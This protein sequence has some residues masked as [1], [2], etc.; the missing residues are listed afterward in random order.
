[1]FSRF[2]ASATRSSRLLIGVVLL[3]AI[4]ITAQPRARA[5]D[6]VKTGSAL[7]IIP[8]D[9]A[10]FGTMLRNKEQFDLFYNSNAYKTLRSLPLVKEAADKLEKEIA[11]DPGNPFAMYQQF[12]KDP[13]NKELVDLLLEGV[14]DEFFVYGGKGWGDMITV[15]ARV[16]NA[17]SWG[18]LQG[19]LG[20]GDPQKA[21]FRAILL[22]LQNSRELL[23]IPDTV[24]GFKLKD[25]KKADNQI[26]RLEKIAGF[27]V[28]QVPQLKGKMTSKKIGDGTFLT[29]E[30]DGSLIPWG[31]VNVKEYEE[32]ND[33]FDPLIKQAQKTTAALSVGIKDGYLL[34]GLTSTS[35]D[36]AKIGG[37]GKSLAG[38]P[39]MAPLAKAAG[40]PLT[41]IGYSS[42]AFIDSASGSQWDFE[43]VAKSL[44]EILGK[45][46]QISAERKKAIE[47]DLDN[48]AADA[49]KYRRE[50]GA[51]LS[52]S[53][54]TPTGFEAF[55]YDYSKHDEL[56]G[57]VC[58]LQN[59]FD[60]NPIL[61]GA[62]GCKV[63]GERYAASVKWL[64]IVY[65]HAEGAMLD[66]A[67]QEAKD[68]YQQFAK[69][70]FP[71]F[72]RFDDITTKQFLPSIKD[73]GLGLVLD[74]KWTS[75][76]WHQQM[77]AHDKPLPMLE[78]GLLVGISDAK[79]FETAMTEYRKTLNELYE[80]VRD[81][82]PG[83][84]NIPE[85]KI[86]VPDTEKVANGTLLYYV[87]PA[88]IGLD[89]QFQ[90]V[91]GVGK[92]VS[93]IALSKGHANRLMGTTA[94]GMKS[95]PI[96]RK[97]DLVGV[98]LLDWPAL[99]DAAAPWVEF[100]MKMSMGKGD[101]I[102]S[103][104]KQAKVAFDVLKCFKGSS[105]ATFLE[106]G[107]LVTHSEIVVK[108]LDRVIKE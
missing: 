7:S 36:L 42:K 5:G 19:L 80:K 28:N 75:K 94:V 1:M 64:K 73:S 99:V 4:V 31:D 49:R 83:K 21:Q 59:H 52:F 93:V 20:G 77:P 25:N 61:A 48:L 78:L 47:K 90:P 50:F 39:E 76:Q 32:K 55:A 40:K 92:D 35:A 44:K 71:I 85:F 51:Q 97:T 82:T 9:A 106:D 86:P 15:F 100:S 62:F 87:I 95:G 70:A 8:A 10:F 69:V 13:E 37:K 18:P 27:L 74:A 41:G 14:S 108:D 33:E 24:L 89:K 103:Y 88:E 107:K 96:S 38:L 17:Q 68:A 34:I 45:A 12:V 104:L 2:T 67:P 43:S 98:G 56:K 3:G 29:I 22:A 79:G 26:K 54:R 30:V 81:V 58:K 57:V 23:R 102:G 16:N 72:K 60:G 53:Y 6:A 65:G 105:S 46:E 101:A 84:E 66:V 11:R 63:T 91:A